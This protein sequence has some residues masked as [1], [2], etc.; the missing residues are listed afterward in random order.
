M[1]ERRTFQE[2]D[3]EHA[4]P[5]LC[6]DRNLGMRTQGS[7]GVTVVGGEIALCHVPLPVASLVAPL[8]VTLLP[9]APPPPLHIAWPPLVQTV[10]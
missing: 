8:P 5:S 10:Y 1:S 6:L 7:E 3:R 2:E 4:K 9:I